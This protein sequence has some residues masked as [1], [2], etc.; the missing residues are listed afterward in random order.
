[1]TTPPHNYWWAMGETVWWD[2]SDSEKTFIEHVAQPATKKIL[3]DL[4]YIDRPIAYSFNSHGFRTAEFASPQAVCFGCSFTMGTGLRQEHTW[5]QQ[6][7]TLTGISVANLAHAGSSNDTALRM[8]LHYLPLLKP[9]YALWLQTD[10]RRVE[11]L[12]DAANVS[13]NLMAND[14]SNTHYGKDQWVR[15]WFASESNQK[16]NVEKNTR[17]FRNLCNELDIVCIIL[18]RDALVTIDLA[19]DLKH[20]G[21]QSNLAMAKKFQSLIR[22]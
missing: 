16:I 5:P 17:A 6:F 19:R 13:V 22:F 1:M 18:P 8:A 20:P 12:D 15:Q 9:R 10:Q 21:T 11:I 14:H 4:Q 2:T 3:Q 7:Q